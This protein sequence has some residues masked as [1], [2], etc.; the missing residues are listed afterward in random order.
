MSQDEQNPSPNPNSSP[1][2]DDD[3]SARRRSRRTSGQKI[4]LFVMIVVAV[5]LV[6]VFMAVNSERTIRERE[7]KE[8]K[9]VMSDSS[10]IQRDLIAAAEASKYKAVE[11]A[12]TPP[13]LPISVPPGT[14]QVIIIQPPKVRQSRRLTDEEK[15]R[16]KK[17]RG[18]KEESLMSKSTLTNAF[19]DLNSGQA[20]V[21]PPTNPRDQ[22]MADVL[23]AAMGNKDG[24]VVPAAIID[25]GA[26]GAG[27]GDV[28]AYQ[29]KTDF[30]YN[31]GATRT[32]QGYSS[33][34]RNAPVAT[35]ELKAGSVL[36]GLLLVGVNSD[37]PGIVL[38][39]ISENVWDTA[40][41]NNLLIPQ[42]TRIIGVYDSKITYGQKRVAIVWNRLIYP[43]GSSLNIA[44]SPGTDM[45]GY[46]GVKGKVDNHYGQLLSAALFTSF[47]TAA[48]DVLADNDDETGPYGNNNNSK[49]SAKDVLVETTGVT[50]ANI[51]AKLAERALEIQPTIIIKPGTR[52]N[53]MVTE[54]VVFMRR[55][56][57]NGTRV[58]GF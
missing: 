19:N 15:E 12:I 16:G 54:D 42:G 33:H 47:F 51:G 13:S 21:T 53:V 41:G 48:V 37:L 26:A 45:A 20:P 35:M 23:R 39:Q 31:Q 56:E 6:F 1:L 24:A 36:P 28:N 22:L 5:V 40:T 8:R 50:I 34:T 29:H 57:E 10:R 27:G 17:Y 46:A 14:S 11:E 25:D 52:F 7:N 30:V 3:S 55:W 4:V 18:L 38:G 9:A 32:P 43:D 58:S 49:K 2:F 44:G